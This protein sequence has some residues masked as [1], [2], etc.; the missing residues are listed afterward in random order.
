MSEWKDFLE[1]EW[2]LLKSSMGLAEEQPGKVMICFINRHLEA[3]DGVRYKIRYEGKELSG[4]TTANGY[5]FTVA[6]K[7]LQPIETWVWSRSRNDYKKLDDVIPQMGKPLLVRKCLNTFKVQAKTHPVIPVAEPKPRPTAPRPAPPPGPSPTTNQGVIV[8]PPKR[9][10]KGNALYPVDRPV[11]DTITPEQLRKIFPKN[12]HG[13]P[14]DEHLKKVADEL[15]TD[16]MKY[17]LDTVYR[18]AHF[19]GQIKQESPSLS[20]KEESFNYTPSGLIGTFS[21]YYGKL[22]K[23]AEEDGRI[24]EKLK[25][26]K[27]KVI[28]KANQEVI[29][30]KVYGIGK[31]GFQNTNPGDGWRYRGRGMHQTTGKANYSNFTVYYRLLWDGGLINF[32]EKPELLSEW[33]YTLR[34]AI[35]YW[36]RNECYKI[37]DNGIDD[38]SID[39]VTKKINPGEIDKNLAGSY[40]GKTNPV[41]NRRSYVKLAYKSFI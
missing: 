26:G 20:G 27:K 11:P 15:N 38:K 13:H 18:R 19:F 2:R 7:T 4:T 24:V 14:T 6:P 22:H 5:C 21:S 3:L 39:G 33:P 10:E 30:N 31:K 17:K 32:V 41:V 28:Q 23:E 29:A 25:N 35:S 36:V 40:E 16:L 34:S 1:R 12:A 37:A 9:D 8:H